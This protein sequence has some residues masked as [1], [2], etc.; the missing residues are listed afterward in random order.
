M[1][2]ATYGYR[3]RRCGGVGR[4]RVRHQTVTPA[5]GRCGDATTAGRGSPRASPRTSATSS[6]GWSSWTTSPRIIFDTM[7]AASAKWQ[8]WFLFQ[9]VPHLPEA[10][11][12]RREEIWLRHFFGQWSYSTTRGC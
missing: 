12:A 6:T 4:A 10:L 3:Q 2:N 1:R 5:S 11:I 9:Q 8:W 7:D